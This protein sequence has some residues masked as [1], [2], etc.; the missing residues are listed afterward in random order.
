[1]KILNYALVIALAIPCYSLSNEKI[2]NDKD[3]LDAVSILSKA[4]AGIEMYDYLA[5]SGGSEQD[6]KLNFKNYLFFSIEAIPAL[7]RSAK[8]NNPAAQYLLGVT[9]R[10]PFIPSTESAKMCELF[11]KSAVSGFLPAVFALGGSCPDSVD[12]EGINTLLE[13]TLS[14]S[15]SYSMYYPA[16]AIIYKF[17]SR[18]SPASLSLPMLDQQTF[19]A[20]GYYALARSTRGTQ[21]PQLQIKLKYYKEAIARGCE[22]AKALA[23]GVEEQINAL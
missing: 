14:S 1:M 4:Q 13:S 16:Q 12:M 9:M 10:T 3:Y 15:K 6:L 19:E 5:S 8:Q 7:Q 18:N 17:C 2:I 22:P 21:I 23:A 20:E 11:N